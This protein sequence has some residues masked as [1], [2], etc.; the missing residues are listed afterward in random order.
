MASANPDRFGS[1]SIEPADL[2]YHESMD[3]TA[4]STFFEE[5]GIS[6]H[7]NQVPC[8]PNGK[9]IEPSSFPEKRYRREQGFFSNQNTRVRSIHRHG[10]LGTDS[11]LPSSLNHSVSASP[12]EIESKAGLDSQGRTISS[13]ENHIVLDASPSYHGQVTE[14]TEEKDLP[15]LWLQS[16]LADDISDCERD[17]LDPISH[18]NYSR[19]ITWLRNH[20]NEQNEQI[21]EDQSIPREQADASITQ[22]LEAWLT[23]LKTGE[24]LYFRSPTVGSGLV[25]QDVEMLGDSNLAK[26]A[27]ASQVAIGESGDIYVPIPTRHFIANGYR[28]FNII[29]ALCAAV[30]PLA[31][32]VQAVMSLLV[33]NHFMK[34]N[35]WLPMAIALIP[36]Y[37][38]SRSPFA[39]YLKNM[40]DTTKV[41][42]TAIYHRFHPR[43]YVRYHVNGCTELRRHY[44]DSRK[45]SSAEIIGRA[46]AAL[47]YGICTVGMV[48]K[49]TEGLPDSVPEFAYYPTAALRFFVIYIGLSWM[50]LSTGFMK[51][52]P[53]VKGVLNWLSDKF[54]T[55]NIVRVA[56]HE[57][58][59]LALNDLESLML[60]TEK[61]LQTK[62][63]TAKKDAEIFI[64]EIR[65]ALQYRISNNLA[66]DT[67]SAT[68]RT[69]KLM[70]FVE[71]IYDADST[72][73]L[74]QRLTEARTGQAAGQGH[75][76]SSRQ[77][78]S[79]TSITESANQPLLADT[80]IPIGKDDARAS[81]YISLN[82]NF[83]GTSFFADWSTVGLALGLAISACAGNVGGVLSL[84]AA[85]G[86]WAWLPASSAMMT[87]L[88]LNWPHA[89]RWVGKAMSYLDSVYPLSIEFGQKAEPTTYQK[90]VIRRDNFLQALNGFAYAAIITPLFNTSSAIPCPAN[91]ESSTGAS[92]DCGSETLWLPLVMNMLFG[93]STLC[94]MYAIKYDAFEQHVI[95]GNQKNQAKQ[96]EKK[97]AHLSA[98]QSKIIRTYGEALCTSL[99]AANKRLKSFEALQRYK[100][101]N[102]FT[103]QIRALFAKFQ[104]KLSFTDQE[105]IGLMEVA[106]TG[107]HGAATVAQNKLYSIFNLSDEG[108][109]DHTRK[110]KAIEYLA[111]FHRELALI[112]DLSDR[113]I[114]D[115]VETPGALQH[116][117]INEKGEIDQP[118]FPEGVTHRQGDAT[119]FR[120]IDPKPFPPTNPGST[121]F[122]T[123]TTTA[124]RLRSG[125][126]SYNASPAMAQ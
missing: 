111:E 24:R 26:G 9:P 22:N 51:S 47:S 114:R 2:G 38:G 62:F 124:A 16:G 46:F 25:L 123:S 34:A 12:L 13:A 78:H 94:F 6:I 67:E 74:Q 15:P 84:F 41:I 35:R 98:T 23:N 91:P 58:L 30:K 49:A 80:Q 126:T 14:L 39:F 69:L 28:T 83:I 101:S 44:P 122:H 89:S 81:D 48:S 42:E 109:Q 4:I 33:L 54:N 86:T 71:Q 55:R 108:Q 50:T 88:G 93:V 104:G 18:P 73:E 40:V 31:G 19:L 119:V 5:I 3:R 60:K 29:P 72:E 66:A 1:D 85:I 118:S 113:D 32:I 103:R 61:H 56:P 7:V 11:P 37:F 57:A 53:L 36:G 8:H 115:Y 21:R 20:L 100:R 106:I 117:A 70:Q 63:G 45:T 112:V 102:A 95:Q 116:A 121:A 43:N 97:F 105:A 59:L 96:P 92:P 125:Q 79:H 10:S 27:R 52:T 68:I 17:T 82:K 64:R 110:A 76:K 90:W 99:A 75:S 65:S 77:S 120:D 107:A 87:P